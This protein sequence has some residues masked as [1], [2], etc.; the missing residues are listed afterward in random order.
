MHE[1]VA[2][3]V[4]LVL[5]S[6]KWLGV[7]KKEE[8]GVGGWIVDAPDKSRWR[9]RERKRERAAWTRISVL[10]SW[11]DCRGARCP[12]VSRCLGIPI[13]NAK[14][15]E[16]HRHI[17]ASGRRRSNIFFPCPPS[18]PPRSLLV[19]LRP[20]VLQMRSFLG[21]GVPGISREKARYLTPLLLLLRRRCCPWARPLYFGIY[22]VP[23]EMRKT[24]EIIWRGS[25]QTKLVIYNYDC[26]CFF[27]GIFPLT[28]L[29]F[30]FA[31]FSFL[32]FN[33]CYFMVSRSCRLLIVFLFFFYLFIFGTFSIYCSILEEEVGCIAQ[34][35]CGK[36]THRQW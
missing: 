10:R 26:F 23:P 9:E 2:H 14:A 17:S 1:A 7:K 36:K 19:S 21:L 29:F 28:F 25:P 24:M 20:S 18:P 4:T 15:G 13:P 8:G 34:N 16:N 35:I 31:F 6:R 11:S 27:E 3:L 5:T 32:F 30:F 33:H 22:T 12:T